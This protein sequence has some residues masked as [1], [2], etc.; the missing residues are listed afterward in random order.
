[1]PNQALSHEENLR[2]L[3]L[4]CIKKIERGEERDVSH[5]VK[6]KDGSIISLKQMFLDTGVYPEYENDEAFLPKSF[7][8]GC[9][10]ILSSQYSTLKRK[11]PGPHQYAR[12]AEDMR[13]LPPTTRTNTNCSTAVCEVCFIAQEKGHKRTPSKYLKEKEPK[14]APDPDPSPVCPDCQRE[15]LR[16]GTHRCIKNDKRFKRIVQRTS[17]E[18][19]KRLGLYIEAEVGPLR[20][21]V[22]IGADTLQKI[23]VEINMSYR[24]TVKMAQILTGETAGLSAEPYYRDKL[25]SSLNI[26]EDHFKLEFIELYA[27]VPTEDDVEKKV[28]HETLVPCVFVKDII[29][30][31]NHVQ[32]ARKIRKPRVKIG[33]DGGQVRQFFYI[34]VFRQK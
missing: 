23:M 31:A 6:R 10:R 3:C 12:M 20:P 15:V 25:S 2:R 1:M 13:N 11:V 21:K 5:E 32:E 8:P 34:Y 22:Q 33:C 18:G 29:A 19:L 14:P 27:K 24:K 17:P 28:L 30:F 9:V 16:M 4:L 7:C 26:L